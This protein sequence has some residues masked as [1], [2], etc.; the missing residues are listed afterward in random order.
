MFL[1]FAEAYSLSVDNPTMSI[2]PMPLVHNLSL[3]FIRGYAGLQLP[4]GELF[5]NH[6]GAQLLQVPTLISTQNR[7]GQ[8]SGGPAGLHGEG[9]RTWCVNNDN[10][11][12]KNVSVASFSEF[13]PCC[14]CV[15]IHIGVRGFVRAAKN[16]AP[17]ADAVIMVAGINHN[18]STAH[19]GDYYRLLLPGTYTITAVAPG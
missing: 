17:L 18:V 12:Y 11:P 10:E 1:V 8:Q 7:M 6:Y 5:W 13:L 19:F 2:H 3:L 9:R 15:Q 4:E 14:V 16:E